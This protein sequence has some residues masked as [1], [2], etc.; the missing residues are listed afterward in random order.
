[1]LYV[2]GDLYLLP[3]VSLVLLVPL[4]RVPARQLAQQL[5]S[6]ILFIVGSQNPDD[7]P[8][9]HLSPYPFN[10]DWLLENLPVRSYFRTRKVQYCN[11]KYYLDYIAIL[12]I[13][14]GS[15]LI[16]AS[17]CILQSAYVRKFISACK[18]TVY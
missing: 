12:S 8:A 6:T 16:K 15:I 7:R 14:S 5:S 17:H 11:L 9:C 2:E 1:V 18:L 3:A 4:N 13:G 10:N